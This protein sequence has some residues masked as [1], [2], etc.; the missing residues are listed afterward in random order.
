MEKDN[1][2]RTILFVSDLH[3]GAGSFVNGRRNVLEEFHSDEQFIDFLHYYSTGTFEHE[4]VELIINGDFFD[5]LAVPYVRYFDDEFWSEK[6][7]FAKYDMILQAH[8]P[9]IDAI[10]AFCSVPSKKIVYILGNHDAEFVFDSLRTHF[11]SLFPQDVREN[12]IFHMSLK[13]YVPV[14]GVLVRHGHEFEMGHYYH[15]Q[16]SIMYSDEGEGYFLAPWG[17]YYVTRVLNKFKEEKVTVNQVRPIRTYLLYGLVFQTLFTIRFMFANIYYF[18]MVRFLYYFKQKTKFKGIIR[19]ILEEIKFFADYETITEDILEKNEGIR[20][21][22]LGHTHKPEYRAYPSGQVFINLGSW[23]KTFYLDFSNA[24][25]GMHLTYAKMLVKKSPD[26][27][28]VLESSLNRWKGT[29]KLPYVE[30]Q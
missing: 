14:D 25:G 6:A 10:V 28:Q 26:G 17:S 12:F 22:I 5:F 21:F 24:Q 15:P 30:F 18:V 16:D 27:K 20:T 13:P 7:A 3:L 2:S 19:N 23:T 9:L 11:L 29:K 4:C 1:A 8:R